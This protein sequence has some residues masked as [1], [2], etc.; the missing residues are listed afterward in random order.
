VTTLIMS[1]PRTVATVAA[2]VAAAVAAAGMAS[3][4]AA[5]EARAQVLA[6]G[7]TAATASKGGL[8]TGVFSPARVALRDGLEV[9]THPL[10]FFVSPNA[11]VRIAHL[12][13]GDRLRLTGEYGLSV[14]TPAMK[15]LQ[16][17]LFPTWYHRQQRVGWIVA[18]RAGVVASV[19]SLERHIATFRADITVG[20]VL[21]HTDTMPLDTYAPLELLFA[22]VTGGY[23]G[24]LGAQYDRLLA[25]RWRMRGYADLYLH[26]SGELHDPGDWP[27]A[28]SPLATTRLGAS[29]DF[30]PGRQAKNRLSLGV[31]WWNYSQHQIDPDTFA[32]RRSNDI[33]PTLDFIY[34]SGP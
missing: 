34:R 8:S 13:R 24:R 2:I 26:G 9:E 11:R 16:G 21:T 20:I 1:M 30:A 17:H 14:P 18:P 5:G 15:L 10:I 19:G 23:R 3:A 4:I 29:V 12:D 6:A 25:P 22:P 31:A 32:P 28:S 33:F 27:F 7:D